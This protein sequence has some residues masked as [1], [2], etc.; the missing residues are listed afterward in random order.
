ML[1]TFY[2]ESPGECCSGALLNIETSVSA[3][4]IGETVVS[5]YVLVPIFTVVRQKYL[6]CALTDN[7]RVIRGVEF[8]PSYFM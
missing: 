6:S 7:I 1:T 4:V 3:N 2:F 8:F 5:P